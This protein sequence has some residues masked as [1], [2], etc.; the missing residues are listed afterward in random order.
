VKKF[1]VSIN[2]QYFPKYVT[3]LYCTTIVFIQN[4][5]HETYLLYGCVLST[6]STVVTHYV[7]HFLLVPM[8]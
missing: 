4:S 6:R 1:L 3:A 7:A 2:K 5:F 8:H